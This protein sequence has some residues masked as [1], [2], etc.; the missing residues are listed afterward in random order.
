MSRVYI[1]G[2]MTGLPAKNYPAFA[3]EAARLRALGHEVINPAEVNAGLE[4]E[5][6]AACMKR[7]I[8]EMLKCDAVQLLPG[9]LKSRGVKVEVTLARALGI[10]VYSPYA[11]LETP[12]IEGIEG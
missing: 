1:A 9:W 11:P 4:H 3:A 8:P 6:W 7:D 2:P 10:Y 12:A 5:G